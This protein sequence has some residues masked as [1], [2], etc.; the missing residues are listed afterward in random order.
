MAVTKVRSKWV[1]G[2]LVFSTLAG[3]EIATFNAA[4]GLF[5]V[6]DGSIDNSSMDPEYMKVLAVALTPGLVNTFAAAVENPHAADCII[7]KVILDITTAG[8]TATAVMNVGVAANGTTGS[9]TL[10]D[11]A[12]INA[13]AIYDNITDKGSNGKTRARWGATEF[14]T[15]QILTEAASALVGTLYIF[16]TKAA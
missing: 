14:V 4:T 8:G 10:I 5:H 11:G 7:H 16:Y 3:V 1:G 12:D 9:D 2:N 15:G 13:D 6:A